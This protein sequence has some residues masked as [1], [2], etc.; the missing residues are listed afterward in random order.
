M[1]P[2][3]PSLCGDAAA[4]VDEV[5]DLLQRV[6]TGS[7]VSEGGC[8]DDVSIATEQP[9]ASDIKSADS[10]A[11]ASHLVELAAP[12]P[13]DR[14]GVYSE[15]GKLQT[16]LVCRPGL[17]HERL[18]PANCNHFLF[19]DVLWVSRAKA[20]H[21]YFVHQMESRGVEVLDLHDLLTETFTHAPHSVSWLLDKRLRRCFTDNAV[22]QHLREFL[23][24]LSPPKLAEHLIGGVAKYEAGM[25]RGLADGFCDSAFVLDPLP[26]SL[27]QRDS[28]CW[29]YGGVSLNSMRSPTRR[30]ETYLLQC[31]YTFH[32]RFANRVHFWFG[33]NRADLIDSAVTVEGGDVMP[34]G[35]GI[36]LV[37]CS[38]RTSEPGILALARKVLSGKN[39]ASRV[40]ICYMPKCRSAMHLDT[41]FNF[42]DIDLVTAYPDVVNKIVCASLTLDPK[43]HDL[44][45]EEHTGTHLLDV[46]R[47]LLGVNLDVVWTGGNVYERER[48]QWDDGNN[49]IVLDRRV[50]VAYDRNV[51]T[52]TLM[53]EKGVEVIEISGGELGRGRG[54]GH[55]M[56]CP[57]S[58]LPA[59][60]PTQ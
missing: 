31:V 26:N 38:E 41:V 54:G 8:D 51:L 36:L 56:T 30:Q 6:R 34:I 18:T 10:T 45:R 5:Q 58:R 2:P 21:A 25:M 44:R 14:F 16:V 35:R 43:T 22:T 20:D 11:S 17:A 27:F 48:E 12:I 7:I 33:H 4:A 29:I 47:S 53:R 57:I 50:V 37:G 39:G 32:P 49:I 9:L 59:P 28:S 52:N 1:S 23:M 55:C 60:F 40:V 24:K 15:C 19:D 42:I 46:L 13:A 3:I